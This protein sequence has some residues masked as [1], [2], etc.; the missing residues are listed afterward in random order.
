RTVLILDHNGGGAI[1]RVGE[2]DTAYGHRRWTYNL[3][4]ISQWADAAD[5]ARNLAWTRSFWSAMRPFLANAV[6]VNYTS[7]QD[8]R[9]IR[10]VYPAAIHER[11]VALKDRWD[12]ENLFR[13]N[14]NVRPTV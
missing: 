1:D 7:D 4:V 13:M 10:D 14:H 6:Y 9:T 3:L 12:P 2:A 8:A 11:L 5:D